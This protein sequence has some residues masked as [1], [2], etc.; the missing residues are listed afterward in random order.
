VT[1][2]AEGKTPKVV[3]VGGAVTP[4]MRGNLRLP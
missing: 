3:R 4:L 2:E 1:V